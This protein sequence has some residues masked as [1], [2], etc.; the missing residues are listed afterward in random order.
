MTDPGHNAS[1]T[2]KML[3]TRPAIPA[4]LQRGSV[5]PRP[6][7]QRGWTWPRHHLRSVGVGRP[8][9]PGR[10]SVPEELGAFDAPEEPKTL[11]ASVASEE[12]GAFAPQTQ[13]G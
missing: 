5:G 1:R 6:H 9:V 4:D 8:A 7:L 12:L 10:S 11:G 2:R 13:K 3:T